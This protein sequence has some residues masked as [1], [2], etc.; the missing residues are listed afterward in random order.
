MSLVECWAC[1]A[2][3]FSLILI[4]SSDIDAFSKAGGDREVAKKATAQIATAE[5]S[6]TTREA[7]PGETQVLPTVV[8]SEVD[9]ASSM[10]HGFT[11]SE[12]EDKGLGAFAIQE[13]N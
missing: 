12:V 10:P 11:L 1:T 13:F 4:A 3:W 9:D 6:A 7:K 5:A 2:G 8:Q